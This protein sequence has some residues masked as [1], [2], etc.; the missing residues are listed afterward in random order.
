MADESAATAASRARASPNVNKL[1]I[2]IP[3]VAGLRGAGG[4]LGCRKGCAPRLARCAILAP[5]YVRSSPLSQSSDAASF[6]SPEPQS[7]RGS[8]LQQLL[9]LLQFLAEEFVLLLQFVDFG[10]EFR[11]PGKEPS[12]EPAAPCR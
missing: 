7:P 12:R 6:C 2:A 1:R 10:G 11:L 8:F 5:P 4:H 3:R 9:D